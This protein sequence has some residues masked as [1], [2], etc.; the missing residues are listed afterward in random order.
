M[1]ENNNKT[2]TTSGNYPKVNIH[3]LLNIM[4]NLPERPTLYA[5]DYKLVVNQYLPNNSII[6]SKDLAEKLGIWDARE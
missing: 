5:M 6:I 1:P 4:R 3:E 2:S